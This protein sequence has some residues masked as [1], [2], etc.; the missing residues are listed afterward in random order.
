[1]R[2]PPHRAPGRA[3]L[4]VGSYLPTSHSVTALTAV[5]GVPAR[6][7]RPLVLILLA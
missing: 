5:R 4:R 7:A 2:S 6:S 1:M 3:A